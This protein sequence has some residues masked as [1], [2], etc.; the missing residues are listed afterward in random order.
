[1]ILSLREIIAELRGKDK[2]TT[3]KSFFAKIELSSQVN[4]NIIKSLEALEKK[5]NHELAELQTLREKQAGYQRI[6]YDMFNGN[7]IN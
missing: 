1:M 3:T 4:T 6:F 7:S 2:S 5:N